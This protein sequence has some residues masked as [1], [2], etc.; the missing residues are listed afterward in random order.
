MSMYSSTFFFGSGNTNVKLI[1]NTYT[2]G[3]AK[4]IPTLCNAPHH[5]FGFFH[6]TLK[7]C[8]KSRLKWIIV[9]GSL[10]NF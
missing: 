7:I 8:G 4:E 1:D 5:P 3:L 9:H 10:C 2:V 6:Q